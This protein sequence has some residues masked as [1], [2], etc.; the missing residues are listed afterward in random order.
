MIMVLTMQIYHVIEGTYYL[1]NH[2]LWWC[3][4]PAL[5]RPPG[6]FLCFPLHRNKYTSIIIIIHTQENIVILKA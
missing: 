2:V 5:P 4:P 6:C 1:S 3:W